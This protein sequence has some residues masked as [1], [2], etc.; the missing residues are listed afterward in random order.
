MCS[1][2]V[3]ERRKNEKGRKNFGGRKKRKGKVQTKKAKKKFIK[4]DTAEFSR[5][6]RK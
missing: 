2:F 1:H 3:Y 6:G 4:T 5:K